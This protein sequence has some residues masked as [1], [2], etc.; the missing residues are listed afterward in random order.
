MYISLP[1]I[2]SNSNKTTTATMVWLIITTTSESN[3]KIVDKDTDNDDEGGRLMTWL[4]QF[5]SIEMTKVFVH[6]GYNFV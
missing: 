5:I 6:K 1:I 3:K 2:H 4:V